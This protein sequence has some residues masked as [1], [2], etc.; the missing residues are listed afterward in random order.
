MTTLSRR[1]FMAYATTVVA[2]A[3]GSMPSP[4]PTPTLSAGLPPSRPGLRALVGERL[5][6]IGSAVRGEPLV[7][8][9]PYRDTIALEFNIAT[10]EHALKFA[11][12]HPER[13]RYDFTEAD[14][15]VDFARQQGMQVRGHTLVWHEEAPAWVAK[16][17]FNRDQLTAILHEHIRSVVGRYR[18]RIQYW[19]VVNEALDDDGSLRK[20]VWQQTI[21][22]G[23]LD[24]AFR[25][26]HEADPDAKL[27]YNDYGAEALG[28]KSDA[29]LDLVQGLI[30]RGVPVDGVG[31]QCHFAIDKP[32]KLPEIEA[33]LTRLASAGFE[34]QV[35]E[36]D[37]RIPLPASDDELSKQAAL[38]GD[39]LRICRANP[40]CTAYVMW[41]FT[42]RHSWVPEFR[43]GY[44]AAH[45]LDQ[46]YAPKPAYDA[47]ANVLSR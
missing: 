33:N 25:A 11:P 32:P 17:N 28:P 9:A 45:I 42:D 21:G 19:D 6:L 2:A 37:V 22:P 23:Y 14:L 30:A 38:Y 35:T 15:I 16:G 27:F 36:L 44:G 40:R 47:L 13:E 31:L 5:P 29:V 41:G 12:V 26:A 43:A 24:I 1:S 10:P 8:E 39:L 3:C 7:Q 34:V 20:T 46:V 18:G 4:S